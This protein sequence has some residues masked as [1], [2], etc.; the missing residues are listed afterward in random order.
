MGRERAA[1]CYTRFGPL[2][3]LSYVRRRPAHLWIEPEMLTRVRLRTRRTQR[4]FTIAL[5]AF[6]R[7]R[8]SEL[9]CNLPGVASTF[10][11]Q[12]GENA[13]EKAELTSNRC[14]DNH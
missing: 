14:G 9:Y 6:A 1:R 11:K 12:G 7:N 5:G 4:T 13:Y 10:T 8:L 3:I 2:R